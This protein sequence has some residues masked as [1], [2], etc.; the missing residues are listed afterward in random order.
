MNEAQGVFAVRPGQPLAWEPGSPIA[1][2]R[3]HPRC[4]WQHTVYAGVFEISRMRD[5]LMEAFR[6]PEE[7]TDFDGRVAGQSALLSFTVNQD[8][9]LIKESVT[10]SSCGWAV[11]RTL[12]PGP[13]DK[14]WLEGFE[15]EE[16]AHVETLVGVADGRIPVAQSPGPESAGRPVAGLMSSL[17]KTAVKSGI[18]AAAGAAATGLGLGP[19]V[20]TVATKVGEEVGDALLNRTGLGE[21]S[22]NEAGSSTTD[23]ADPPRPPAEIGTK[24]L[25]I[26]DLV[27]ITRWVTRELGVGEALEPDAIRIKSQQVRE[28]RADES[29][30]EALMNSFFAEDLARVAN[31]VAEGDVGSALISF[32][33][34]EEFVDPATRVDVRTGLREVLDGVRPDRAP[35]GR[36]PA[37]TD[38]PLALSQQ[39]AVNQIMDRLGGVDAAGLYAVN[40]PPGTGKTTMLRDLVAAIVV[41]RA[42]RLVELTSPQDAFSRKALSWETDP[43]SGRR[44]IKRLRPLVSELTGFEMVLASSNNGAVQNVTLEIPAAKSIGPSWREQSA[45]LQEPAGLLLGSTPAWGSVAACL[46]RRQLRSDFVEAF[47]WGNPKERQAP[48][49]EGSGP[50]QR[51][52]R[53]LLTEHLKAQGVG[54]APEHEPPLGALPWDEAV[55]RFRAARAEVDALVRERT[56]LAELAARLA[57]PDP[58]LESLRSGFA[59]FRRVQAELQ[60]QFER[61]QAAVTNVIERAEAQRRQVEQAAEVLREAAEY[62]ER[63]TG[64]VEGAETLLQE[65]DRLHGRP[66]FVRRLVSRR[67]VDRWEDQRAPFVRRLGEA[68]DR[69]RQAE[70]VRTQR[71]HD[72]LVG[73][74]RLQQLA[75][76]TTELLRAARQTAGRLEQAGADMA[77]GEH[78]VR[79]RQTRLDAERRELER[80]REQWGTAFPGAEWL[81]G[82]D[83]RAAM[84]T[85]ELSAPWMDPSFAEARTRLFLAA[86]DL[87]QALIAGAAKIVHEN[88]FAAMEVIKGSAPPD[89]PAETVLAAWQMLFLVVPVVSTTFASLSRMFD[90]LGRESLGWLLIDE[91]GQA[92]PQQAVGALW[93]SR[94]A[95]VVGDPLQLEPVVTLPMTG[96]KRLCRHFGVDAQ[97]APGAGSVQSLADRQTPYGTWLGGEE[98]GPVWVGSPL[99]V[100]RR[101][102]RL[103]FDV[104]NEIAYDGMMVYGVN[105]RDDE[106]M[107]LTRSVWLHVPS[108]A[109]GGKWNPEEG[110]FAKETLRLVKQ[111]LAEETGKASAEIL[112]MLGESVFVVSPFREIST[113]LSRAVASRGSGERLLPEGRVGT[114][115]T[116]QGKE[117]DIVVM[118]L[119]TAASAAGSRQWASRSPNLLNVAVTRARR[120]LI[121]IGDRTTWSRHRYFSTLAAHPLLHPTD[122][123]AWLR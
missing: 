36:W 11:S 84:E 80:A 5:V 29:G 57:V 72:L 96:Q 56:R 64:I 38:Q 26:H 116:T 122:A 68:D 88:L 4:V 17:L 22:D 48:S 28:D 94:R 82:P 74:Q 121:V 71:E 34:P 73:R 90:R 78:Q 45:Y 118:V 66:G 12:I 2:R 76:D 91:A 87:H 58:L 79:A 89:L 55:A 81:A 20:G 113:Q 108:A 16:R 123:A 23:T 105:E 9:R 13:Q 62:V 19:I 53:Q 8:G 10:L 119:G 14:K 115:H 65:Q 63:A 120:R 111:R 46:G 83:D 104:S 32:L 103:M 50:P 6:S 1:S 59:E 21:Q 117:A 24:R 31:A 100:H 85:R 86:L 25:D 109:A 15:D 41:R 18:G 43:V 110:R 99:R 51:G 97:W 7:E 44:S 3:P 112:Q 98:Q 67:A 107:P 54:A 33:T 106:G 77:A 39:F 102:D 92:A 49:A 70:A 69:L 37:E 61:Q 60:R 35:V 75:A 42:E 101:C 30:G 40:G 27:A 52:L 47:W 95:V 93:R 114:V